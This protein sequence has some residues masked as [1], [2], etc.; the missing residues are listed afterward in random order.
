MCAFLALCGGN[1]I[2][3]SFT[4]ELPCYLLW[5]L[6][7]LCL[8]DN[9]GRA[10]YPTCRSTPR[11][12]SRVSLTATFRR[13]QLNLLPQNSMEST[14]WKLALTWTTIICVYHLQTDIS[15]GPLKQFPRRTV[16]ASLFTVRKGPQNSPFAHFS[17][18]SSILRISKGL[19]GNWDLGLLIGD[20]YVFAHF[21]DL[22]SYLAHL[23][24]CRLFILLC[25]F[26][27]LS[28]SYFY[29]AHL[30]TFSF[31]RLLCAFAH[32]LASSF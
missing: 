27:A 17:T 24:T 7:L 18:L 20:V 11:W 8:C 31:I 14:T 6:W 16:N 25:A 3:L 4:Y 13:G 22:S 12:P 21:S 15:N 26:G 19:S 29:Y 1:T 28:A 2:S 30:R 5:L 10:A 23:R 32:S 9:E